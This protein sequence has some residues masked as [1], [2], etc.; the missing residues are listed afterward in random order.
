MIIGDEGF[1]RIACIYCPPGASLYLLFN[2]QIRH[3][4]TAPF[5]TCSSQGFSIILL[6]VHDKSKD[7]PSTT[8]PD[9]LIN[10]GH[11]VPLQNTKA[12][13]DNSRMI[14]NTYRA[15]Y[16]ID[17]SSKLTLNNIQGI[18]YCIWSILLNSK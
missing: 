15:K 8:K 1:G 14:S 16:H 5:I 13:S 18:V 6:L 10:S 7:A 9:L 17:W 4:L 3:T 11:F 12:I 2:Q